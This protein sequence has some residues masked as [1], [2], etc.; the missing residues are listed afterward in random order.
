MHTDTHSRLALVDAK[1]V[2]PPSTASRP[3]CVC[4]LSD[5]VA[6]QPANPATEL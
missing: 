2:L 5:F 4:S 3:N 6:C 1:T